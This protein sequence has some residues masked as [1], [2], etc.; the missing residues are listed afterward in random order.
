LA[1]AVLSTALLIWAGYG[2]SSAALYL[3]ARCDGQGRGP[4]RFVCGTG[5]FSRSPPNV[6]GIISA[7]V[8]ASA[9]TFRL[10]ENP[11][12]NSRVLKSR[13]KLSLA[14]GMVLILLSLAVPQWQIASHFGSWNPLL[15][16]GL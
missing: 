7:A 4:I 11:V 12:R 13:T 15:E 6:P 8:A 3:F 9:I 16:N 14:I 5:R 2:N 1:V 10:G